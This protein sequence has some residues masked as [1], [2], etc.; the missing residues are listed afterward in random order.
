MRTAIRK[1]ALTVPPLRRLYDFAMLHAQGH[2]ESQ[3]QLQELNLAHTR[4]LEE[5]RA[6][7]DSVAESRRQQDAMELQLYVMRSDHQRAAVR[8]EALSV[9]L[10]EM[11][12]QASQNE[13]LEQRFLELSEKMAAGFQAQHESF[14]AIRH[15]LSSPPVSAEEYALAQSKLL[16][17]LT[18]LATDIATIKKTA[19]NGTP[20]GSATRYL[21]L[22]ENSLTGLL[23]NDAPMDPWSKSFDPEVRAIGRDWPTSALTMIGSARLRN[24][25][26]LI[27]RAIS[28]K[29]PGDILE[30]GVW[31]GGACILARAV[32]AVH[33]VED[34]R[35]WVADSFEGLPAPDPKYPSDTGD[36]H[37]TFTQLQVSLEEVQDNFRKY[38]LLDKQVGFL[39]G[40]F[41]DTLTKAPI[42]ALSVLR[43]DGDMYGSTIETLEALYSKVS[44]GGYIII[45]DYILKGCRDAVHDFRRTASINDEIHDVDG[46]AVYW[47]KTQ[48]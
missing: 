30:A 33:D 3:R 41:K 31:R 7:N 16:G 25:R 19:G 20:G 2:A 40:W 29:V 27:E 43:L 22:L 26:T 28:E 34:R 8:N 18:M 32:L 17:K 24:F 45:D 37:S 11:E 47:K 12:T 44:T 48:P 4:V 10:S 1:L 46:A 42:H 38:G 5:L 39:K 23:W 6:A 15:Q 9:A 35:V 14:T 13:S 21:D 36:A